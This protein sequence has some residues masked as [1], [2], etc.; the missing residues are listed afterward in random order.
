MAS[1]IAAARSFMAMTA[2]L[3]PINNAP[4]ANPAIRAA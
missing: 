1:A 4:P 2:P 3:P